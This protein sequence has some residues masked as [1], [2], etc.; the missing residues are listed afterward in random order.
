MSLY[1]P[2]DDERA[3]RIGKELLAIWE[4]QATFNRLFRSPPT[5]HA[6]RCEQT[7]DFVLFAES[8]MH[9]LLRTM[10]WKK[11]RKQNVEENAGHVR[12]ECADVFKC[13][14][15]L[16]Q[17]NGMSKPE[18]LIDA[19]WRK[20]TVVRQRY[21]EEW[22]K[23]VDTD[24]AIV[25]IDNVLCDYITGICDWLVDNIAMTVDQQRR[26]RRMRDEQIVVNAQS[27]GVDQALWQK[28]KHA[29]RVSGGK[30][31][32]PAFDDA[33]AFLRSLH[34]LGLQIVLVTSRPIDRY[35][36]MY[37]DTLQWLVDNDLPF[38]F[39]WWSGDKAERVLEGGLRQHV[40][41]AVDDDVR[42]V[43]QYAESRIP[44][45]W[46]QRTTTETITSPYVYLASS[47]DEVIAVYVNTIRRQ[48]HDTSWPIT[49]TPSTVPTPST[50]DSHHV[51]ESPADPS[52]SA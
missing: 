38:D 11:H 50:P 22:V 23:S 20:T 36:N 1:I 10:S 2:D 18:D 37:T 19:Y 3:L 4:D 24:C 13:T 33:R 45:I 30:R 26:L 16:F 9:E 27:V 41:F 40:R 34:R 29:F 8:E 31:T 47:L 52:P 17:I 6:E 46:L 32:L 42:Y 35:P 21:T 51:S 25:D 48:E 7:R 44:V 39:L 15:S 43:R 14:L 5:T 49:Q 12:D 28:W